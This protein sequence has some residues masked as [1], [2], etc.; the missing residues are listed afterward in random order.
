VQC[1]PP[2]LPAVE[3]QPRNR[4]AEPVN[5]CLTRRNPIPPHQCQCAIHGGFAFPEDPTQ[6]PGIDGHGVPREPTETADEAPGAVAAVAADAERVN[7]GEALL[8]RR[9]PRVPVVSVLRGRQAAPEAVEGDLVHRRKQID[10]GNGV[11]VKSG[12]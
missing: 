9:N 8:P 7:Q 11:A 12:H 1:P 6:L 2:Q 5:V 10:V 3:R 4:G